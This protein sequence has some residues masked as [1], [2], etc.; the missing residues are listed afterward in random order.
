[1]LPQKI[2]YTINTNPPK[3]G[4]EYLRYGMERIE[5]LYLKFYSESCN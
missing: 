4:T 2:K 3:P 1:M 5:E